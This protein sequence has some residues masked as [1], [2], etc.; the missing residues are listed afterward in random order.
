MHMVLAEEAATIDDGGGEREGYGTA[1]LIAVADATNDMS[2][3][4]HFVLLFHAT[5]ACCSL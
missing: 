3:I 5:F 1:T 2:R 4:F